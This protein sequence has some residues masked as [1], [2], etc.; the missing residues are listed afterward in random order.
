MRLEPNY[1][2][3]VEQPDIG[4]YRAGNCDIDYVIQFR[5]ERPGPHLWINALTHGNE[6]CGAIALDYLLRH[7]VRPRSGL[8]TLS[9][10]NVGA[11]GNRSAKHP[12]GTRFIDEDMNRVWDR[13]GSSD[14]SYELDRARQLKP[15]ADSA[16]LLVDLHS[17]DHPS[18]PL[19]I[20]GAEGNEQ[21]TTAG[22]ELARRIGNP[23]LLI[24]DKGH[25]AGC[26]LRD[27]Q[28]FAE[29]HNGKAAIVVECGAHWSRNSA[30]V[31]ID[32][33]LRSIRTLLGLGREPGEVP[34]VVDPPPRILVASEVTITAKTN[35]FRF[36]DVYIGGEVIEEA[37]TVIGKDGDELIRTPYDR[38]FLVMPCSVEKGETPVRF[39]RIQSGE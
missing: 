9:F 32:V 25:S 34:D 10:A 17:M 39:G 18:R 23:T 8:L 24:M 7:E 6:V 12:L 11:Y 16:D 36:A 28:P 5:G 4:C 30:H 33:C 2:V 26:R 27:Y 31:A 14:A 3:E 21:S 20:V 35:R 15:V 37:G 19:A 29:A 1:Y 38:C 22:L 13:L